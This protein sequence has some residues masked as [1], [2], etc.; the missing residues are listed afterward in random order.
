[1]LNR[2][3]EVEAV[4]AWGVEP[5]EQAAE[6]VEFE[7]FDQ[8]AEDDINVPMEYPNGNPTPVGIPVKKINKGQ[9]K[10]LVP[11]K[12]LKV[13]NPIRILSGWNWF[14]IQQVM[15]LPV[16]LPL[17]Q[18]LN[19]SQQLHKEVAWGMQSSTP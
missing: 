14:D 10:E 4:N 5:E 2:Q 7:G 3:W 8:L 18:L 11:I 16:T 19:E 15:D 12:E 17:G 13:P 1:M 9:V 6:D